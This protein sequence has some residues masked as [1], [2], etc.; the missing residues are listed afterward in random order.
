MMSKIAKRAE[1]EVD[2]KLSFN[3]NTRLLEEKLSK[4]S[5]V[6]HAICTISYDVMAVGIMVLTKAGDSCKM[7]S[8]FR[9][10]AT[11]MGVTSHKRVFRQIG[12]YWGVCPILIG[13]NVIEKDFFGEALAASLKKHH[14][15]R[16]DT[17]VISANTSSKFFKSA[18]IVKIYKI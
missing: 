4:N 2:Y 18:N 12:L 16:G 17:I 1:R 13:K 5:A 3:K 14:A 9:P 8:S 10:N 11:I 7:I 15:E 6:A